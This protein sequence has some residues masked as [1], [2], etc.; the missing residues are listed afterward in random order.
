MIDSASLMVGL[1]FSA[2][3][4]MVA[5]VIGW[6]HARSERYLAFGAA[7]I[8]L[9][10]LSLVAL[11]L[12]NGAYSFWTQVIPY[13]MMLGGFAFVLAASR[14][15]NGRPAQPAFWL[16]ATFILA[17]ILAQA[18]GLTGLGHALLNLGAAMHLALSGYQ[19]WRGRHDT[20]LG[21]VATAV[22][23][24]T[25]AAS[26][27]ACAIMIA[28]EGLWVL[29]APPSNWAEA[30]NVIVSLMGITGIGAMTL[31]LHHARATRRHRLEADTD[32]LTG[33]LNRRALFRRYAENS[34]AT[35]LAVIMFDLDHFKQINDRLGHAHGDMV[36]TRFAQVLRAELRQSDIVARIGGEEF[37]AIL[38]GR[39]HD[40]ASVVAERIRKA[41]ADQQL[42]IGSQA[43][44][45]TVSAGLAIGGLDE[46]FSSVL[47]RA[48]SALYKAK[49]AGRNQ[50][51]IAPFQLVA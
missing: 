19:Y 31:T 41:L 38:P 1:A 36:L 34:A 32:A 29:D 40:A 18:L 28:I 50:V 21:M 15:F 25:V 12:R 27:L 23:Y 39:D 45:A 7:G 2:A 6:H 43:E 22:L 51:H 30:I 14:L 24:L 47:S 33:V 3:S 48:D 10:V 20:Y 16:G 9:I 13:S 35:G 4:L 46:P 37:C 8:G 5:L 44:I 26:F 11:G 42:P 17:N 49:E